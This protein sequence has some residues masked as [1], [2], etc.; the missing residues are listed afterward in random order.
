M[1]NKGHLAILKK[2]VAAWNKW[3]KQ[4]P[5]ILPDLSVANLLKADLSGTDLSRANLVRAQ[6]GGANLREANLS[7]ANLLGVNLVKA[8]LSGANLALAKLGG[9]IVLEAGLS[10]ADLSGANL[11]GVG[12]LEADL[13][14]ANLGEV[15]LSGANLNGAKLNGAELSGADFSKATVGWTILAAVDLSTAKGLDTVRHAGPST[16]GVD[17][18]YRSKG[19]IPEVFLRGA[20]LPDEFIAYISSLVRRPIEFYSCFISYS[21]KDQEFADRLYEGLQNKGVRCWFAPHDVK[22]GEKLHEQID[23]AIR[24]HDKLLLILSE[25][26]MNSEWVKTEIFNAREREVA[27]K[28]RKLFPVRLVPF[29]TLYDWKCFDAKTGKDLAREIAEYFI[30]DFANWKD[31]DSFQ[32]GFERLLKDLKSPDAGD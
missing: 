27:E 14:G 13:S 18:I 11:S 19:K 9:A 8:D 16:I 10:G 29:E 31:H 17:T 30:P 7:G 6:L 1:A 25:H 28:K 24:L 3:R 23:E 12:L 22:A 32:N 21:G 2:G 4:H 26:S 20:G 5:D 15:N